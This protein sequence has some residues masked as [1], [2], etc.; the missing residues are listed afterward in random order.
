MG[1]NS[2]AMDERRSYRPVIG[3]FPPRH[4]APAAAPL[5]LPATSPE[6]G[7]SSQQPTGTGRTPTAFVPVG[8]HLERA[9]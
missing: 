6:R 2:S 3:G 9:S 8:P 1:I 7:S 4:H 5:R